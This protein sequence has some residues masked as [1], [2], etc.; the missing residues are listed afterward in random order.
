LDESPQA[1]QLAQL[2]LE[3]ILLFLKHRRRQQASAAMAL[4]LEILSG[5]GEPGA[6][7]FHLLGMELLRLDQNRLA[8]TDLAE[9]VEHRG[10]ADFL[11]LFRREAGAG[12]R[13]A[14]NAFQ[15]TGQRKGERGNPAG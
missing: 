11:E 3:P 1:I 12:V 2:L 5:Q 6:Q 7:Q 13:T 4:K 8:Y 10:I 15:G 14:G 9:I